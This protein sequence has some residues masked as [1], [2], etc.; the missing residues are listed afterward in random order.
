VAE[1]SEN[2]N[3]NLVGKRFG[4][5]IKR[6]GNKGNQRRYNSKHND[7]NNTLNFS[8]YNCSKQERIKIDRPKD[9]HHKN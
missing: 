3:L 7:S 8:C 6:K 2:E 5:Y 4:K 1:S 9:D